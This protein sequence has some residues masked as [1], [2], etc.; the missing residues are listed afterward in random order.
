V[1]RGQFIQ[2]GESGWAVLCS[3]NNS[4][5]LLVFHNDLDTQPET[6]S[7]SNDQDYVQGMG[8]GR[9]GYSHGIMSVGPEYIR[10]NHRAYGGPEPPPMDHQGIDD[11]F[12][13]KASST[14]YFYRGQWLRLAGS[15]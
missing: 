1:I 13:G 4:T 15:D 2:N 3:V 5:E 6:I 11:A 7:A 14:W 9:L 8:D 12:L 10:R